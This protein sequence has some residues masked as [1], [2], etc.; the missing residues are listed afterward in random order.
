[1]PVETVDPLDLKPGQKQKEIFRVGLKIDGPGLGEPVLL[2]AMFPVQEPKSGAPPAD[3]NPASPA[4][5]GTAPPGKL[6]GVPP[7]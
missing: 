6:P 2:E 5:P 3:G 7:R 4:T 1:M